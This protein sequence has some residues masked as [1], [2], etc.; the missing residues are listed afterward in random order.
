M[1]TI[2]DCDHVISLGLHT[3]SAPAE[4]VSVASV[5]RGP[6]GPR[7]EKGEQGENGTRIVVVPYIDWPPSD[8]EP[9]VLYLRG[10]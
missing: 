1:T 8:P 5:H 3:K 6:A 2:H 4:I 10:E 9:D 7:G